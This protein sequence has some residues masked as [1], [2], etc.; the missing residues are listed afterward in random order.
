MPFSFSSRSIRNRPS[1]QAMQA[2]GYQRAQTPDINNPVAN[3]GAL[4]SANPTHVAGGMSAQEYNAS[5]AA[6]GKAVSEA[7]RSDSRQQGGLA[8]VVQG[9]K[10][11]PTSRAW[12][13]L[14]GAMQ[15]AGA[16]RMSTGAAAGLDTKLGFFDEPSMSALQQQRVNYLNAS[17]INRGRF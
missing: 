6:R 1:V 4:A 13:A 2:G 10:S 14:F 3:Y 12:D 8:N 17:D 16:D 15:M 11:V 7:A 9:I 5:N